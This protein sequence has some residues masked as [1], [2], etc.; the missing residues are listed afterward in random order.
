MLGVA[1][2]YHRKTH[3]LLTDCYEAFEKMKS[4]FRPGVDLA[5]KNREA[6]V[7]LQENFHDFETTL[8]DLEL[9]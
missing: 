5:E 6:A 9:V 7:F 2:I 3:Y 4:V 1:K 8:A